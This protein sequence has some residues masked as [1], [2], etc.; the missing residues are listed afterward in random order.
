VEGWSAND[1]YT[2]DVRIN[3]DIAGGLTGHTETA[4]CTGK[5][6]K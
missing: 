3:Y 6:E 4:T 2:A 1:Q 5:I